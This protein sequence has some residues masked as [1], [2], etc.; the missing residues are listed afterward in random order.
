MSDLITADKAEDIATDLYS[1]SQSAVGD[2]AGC[3]EVMADDFWEDPNV[4]G[5]LLGD[6]IFDASISFVR[7]YDKSLSGKPF[8]K[9]VDEIFV[10]I[11]KAMLRRYNDQ[12]LVKAMDVL[13]Q[14]HSN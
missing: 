11:C 5:D 13:I 7:K 1:W 6:R 12:A 2:L 14:R 10:E 8:F 4:M 3:D 9:V